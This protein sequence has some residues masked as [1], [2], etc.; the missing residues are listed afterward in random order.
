[1]ISVLHCCIVVLSCSCQVRIYEVG[2][3]TAGVVRS[4]ESWHKTTPVFLFP[5]VLHSRHLDRSLIRI[6]AG[7]FIQDKWVTP[8]RG[9]RVT[10]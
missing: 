1:M 6:S 8:P 3:V 7:L 9:V 2:I 5:E 4:P 10:V